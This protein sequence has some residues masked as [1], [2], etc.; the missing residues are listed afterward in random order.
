M[1]AVRFIVGIAIGCN[2]YFVRFH[3][4]FWNRQTFQFIFI[5]DDI[6]PF[7]VCT[8][9]IFGF[10]GEMFCVSIKT[11]WTVLIGEA[12]KPAVICKS[13]GQFHS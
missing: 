12:I 2:A 8:Q 5:R 13:C 11:F 6:N 4:I 9:Y 3:T 10:T 7:I 1:F